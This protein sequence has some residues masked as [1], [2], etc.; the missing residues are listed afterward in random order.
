MASFLARAEDYYDPSDTSA[1]GTISYLLWGGKA[2]KRWADARV[3][4]MEALDALEKIA[5]RK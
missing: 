2:G 3:K 5:R 1:C 4:E